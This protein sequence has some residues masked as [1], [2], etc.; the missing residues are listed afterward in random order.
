[1]ACNTSNPFFG[2]ATCDI[3]KA[4]A[5]A[6]VAE[7]IVLC[8]GTTSQNDEGPSVDS[9]G[10]DEA[11][12][13]LPGSQTA[14]ADAIFAIGKP[15][16]LLLVNGGIVQIDEYAH[17]AAAVVEVFLPALQAPTL[18][19]QLYGHTNR[20][21]KLPVTYYSG[22]LPWNLTDM[23]VSTGIGRTYRYYSGKPLYEFGYGLSYS[24]FSLSC[25]NT[26]TTR[27]TSCEPNVDRVSTTPQVAATT[28]YTC[29]VTNL[30][31]IDGDE[32]VFLYHRPRDSPAACAAHARSSRS[33]TGGSSRWSLPKKALVDWHRVHVP[34]GKT[35]TVPFTIDGSMLALRGDVGPAVKTLH[36][37][38]HSVEFSRGHGETQRMTI[39]VACK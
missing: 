25:T 5:A 2:N 38:S 30:G 13:H 10:H 28:G 35:A 34:A 8:L 26:S 27:W 21:G 3:A 1:M 29:D 32:V 19:A 33:S 6:R 17:K 9:E 11:D 39:D 7:T 4:V 24:N 22:R 12:Y 23:A 37:G 18:A 14:L 36:H 20:W 16:I 31:N 15:V